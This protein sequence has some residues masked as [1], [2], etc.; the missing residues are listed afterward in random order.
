[1]KLTKM[2]IIACSL[3]VVAVI[4]CTT[5]IGYAFDHALVGAAIGGL[6]VTGCASAISFMAYTLLSP[7]G[8]IDTIREVA[9]LMNVP[10]R[11]ASK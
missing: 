2:A 11:L 7:N 4:G 10:G 1:M 3:S 9:V 6:I 8:V 5:L